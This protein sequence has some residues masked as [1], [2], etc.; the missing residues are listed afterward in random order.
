M[1]EDLGAEL[2]GGLDT[3]ADGAGHCMSKHFGAEAHLPLP[4]RPQHFQRPHPE[5]WH[6]HQPCEAWLP[7]C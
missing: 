4:S 7:V 5:T 2:T 1:A 3:Q 6:L